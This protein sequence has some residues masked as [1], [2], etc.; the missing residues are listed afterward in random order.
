M[1]VRPGK[2]P[3]AFIASSSMAGC[4]LPGRTIMVG[5][6]AHD[7]RMAKAAGVYA[8]GVSWGFHT[9]E[10]VLEGG[11]DHVADDFATL[12]LQLDAFA[13]GLA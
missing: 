2:A 4:G 10:E 3:I 5:D 6:T 8:Q 9:A 1:M 13:A 11:A 12:N 7:M